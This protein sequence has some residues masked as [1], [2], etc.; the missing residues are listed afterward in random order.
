MVVV[1]L[2]HTCFLALLPVPH[3]QHGTALMEVLKDGG[4]ESYQDEMARDSFSILLALH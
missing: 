1:V 4:N 2:D 3:Q